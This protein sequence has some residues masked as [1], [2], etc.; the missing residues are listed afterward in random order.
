MKKIFLALTFFFFAFIASAQVGQGIPFSKG[1]TTTPD[2]MKKKDF[3]IMMSVKKAMFC[4]MASNLFRNERY[5]MNKKFN[6]VFR[7]YQAI[8][9]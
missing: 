7:D 4:P 2:F 9:K 6:P 3:G 8:C 1:P 5:R